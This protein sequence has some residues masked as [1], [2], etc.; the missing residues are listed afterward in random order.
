MFIQARGIE[1]S[2][3]KRKIVKGMNLVIEKNEILTV[4]GPNGSGEI[5]AY[6]DV[7]RVTK[8]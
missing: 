5:N 7:N 8:S 3:Q 4:I 1:K 2:Y 6:G